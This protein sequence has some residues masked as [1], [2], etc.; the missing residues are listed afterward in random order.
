MGYTL[1]FDRRWSVV[2]VGVAAAVCLY[3]GAAFIAE[4]M[5]GFA[6]NTANTVVSL[7]VVSTLSVTCSSTVSI[8][9]STG[10]TPGQWVGTGGT[11]ATCVPITNNSLGYTLKWQ[12]TTGSGGYGTGHLNSNNATGGRP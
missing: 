1:S 6:A 4:P 5:H 2:T 12:I 7:Q 9:T 3:L 10:A 8:T 11:I